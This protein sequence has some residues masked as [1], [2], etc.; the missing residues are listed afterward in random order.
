MTEGLATIDT[1]RA[2]VFAA[3]RPPAL[4]R[5]SEWADRYFYLSPE[6]AAEPGRWRTLPYQR[7]P[8]DAMTDPAIERIT[9]MKSSRIGYT[10]MLDATIGFYMHQDPCPISV[11]QPTLDDA[12]GYSKEEIAPML[13]DCA[14][15]AA[16]VP[17]SKTRDSD[18][19]ILHKLFPG[20]VLSVIG[21]NSGRGFRR[22]TRRVMAMDEI[23]AY[24]PS[25]GVEGD[26]VRLAERRTETFWNRKI[27][28]GST[29]LLA[30]VSRIERMFLTGDQRRFEVP[31]TQCGTFAYLVFSPGEADAAGDPV[32]HFMAW[33]KHQP[34]AAHF[35]CRACGGVIEHRDKRA[36]VG[37]GRWRAAA[38]FTGHA[39]FHIWTAYSFSPNAT[40]GQ[41]A[42]EF[43]AANLEGR[44]ALKTF[45]NTVLAQTWKDRGDAPPW[46]TLYQRRA[47]YPIGTCP[48]GV[49]FLTCGVD[50]QKDRLMYEVVGWGRGKRSWSIDIGVLPGDTADLTEAGPW[51]ALSAL[52]EREYP[53]T[54]DAD[55]PAPRALRIALLAVD[56]GFNTQ[57]VYAWAK[58]YP[59]SR[60][61]AIKGVDNASMLVGHPSPVDVG[62][63]GRRRR[64][65]YRVW[66]V[67][68]RLAKG[69]LYAWLQLVP[70]TDE[71]RDAGATEAPGFCTFPHYGEDY[72]KQLTA[73]QL[74]ST[75]SKKGY[76]VFTWEVIPGRENHYLDARVYARAAAAVVGLDRFRES[77]WVRMERALGEEPPRPA[78]P[79]GEGGPPVAPPPASPPP[80]AG[81]RDPWFG[82]ARRRGWMKKPS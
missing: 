32:G 67:S 47:M 64:G 31:C 28:A 56:S 13:R 42:A 38:P 52:L 6:S 43:V 58:G 63:R 53:M 62:P 33:P 25:A 1:I 2:R 29:P 8:L 18:S 60:V 17:E 55:T 61:I 57:Q 74:L 78:P 66:P 7:E 22:V 24:P 75:T 10:K 80:A 79:S 36:I 5:G 69:E 41:I 48:R 44:E 37:A 81:R 21:A 70:V 34:E 9:F 39:S 20:G 73:E 76:T 40:W 51:V 19:T 3:L 50:V 45:V 16:L 82:R 30:G 71:A 4:L 27:I 23:D 11:V 68:S 35:V 59:M 14:V 54:A 15:L 49:L 77:D 72:F 46:E 12:Q 26:P 65:G